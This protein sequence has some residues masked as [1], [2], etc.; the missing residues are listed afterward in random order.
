VVKVSLRNELLLRL[1]SLSFEELQ[2]L[3]LKLTKQLIKFLSSYPEL[4]SQIGGAYLPL[5]AEIAPVYQELLH[6]IPVNLSY[7]V[8]I[9]GEMQ[10]G[11]PNGMPKGGTWLDLP[12]HLATPEWL[13]VPGVGFDLSG[14]RLGRGK[15]FYDRYLQDKD[16][17]TVGLAWS[18]QIVKKIPVE[19][20]DIHMDYI[21]TEDFCWDVNRQEKF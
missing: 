9:D 20:H 5:K 6:G 2:S 14:A 17:L 21:I 11:I 1:S 15:G 19:E 18:E 16:V 12:Y 3:S 8:L 7:P 10:F 4:T 13:L